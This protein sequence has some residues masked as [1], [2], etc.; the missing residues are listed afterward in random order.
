MITITQ[1]EPPDYR[2][3]EFRN[4]LRALLNRF[5]M[6]NGSDTPDDALADYLVNCLVAFD[7]AVNCR[8]EREMNRFHPVATN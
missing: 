1:V 3:P 8:S 7:E 4:E 5:S 6:E 2:S